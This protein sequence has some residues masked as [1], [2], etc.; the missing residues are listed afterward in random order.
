LPFPDPA[1][2]EGSD[3][4]KIAKVR[5]IRDQI[6]EWLLNPNEGAFSYKEFIKE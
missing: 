6:K 1:K 3:E 2:V 5:A 4:E